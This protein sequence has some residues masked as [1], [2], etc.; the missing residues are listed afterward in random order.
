MSTSQ[1]YNCV[2]YLQVCPNPTQSTKH[3]KHPKH[4]FASRGELHVCLDRAC[5]VVHYVLFSSLLVLQHQGGVIHGHDKLILTR[6]RMACAE[7]SNR[8]QIW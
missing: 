2:Q 4:S 5:Y 6:S 3:G 1:N 7:G 8:Q